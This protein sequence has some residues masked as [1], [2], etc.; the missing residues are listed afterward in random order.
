MAEKQATMIN[1]GSDK[2]E[3]VGPLEVKLSNRGNP[4]FEQHPDHPLP[5][6]PRDVWKPVANYAEASR[7]CRRYIATHELGGGNW[8]G[9]EIRQAGR[10][11]II[12][13]VSYNGRVWGAPKI[14]V[15]DPD[16][17]TPVVFDPAS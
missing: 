14:E 3:D 1:M 17:T 5:G 8:T 10:R 11:K 13:Y 12:A 7:L 9:G 6:R 2:V 15:F 16:N 4:D